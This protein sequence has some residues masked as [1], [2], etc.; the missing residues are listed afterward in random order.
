MDTKAGAAPKSKAEDANLPEQ[1]GCGPIQFMAGD[2]LYQRHLHFD[3]VADEDSIGPRE[4]FEAAAHSVR[5]ILAQRWVLTEKTYEQKN[6]KRV[7]YLSMEFLAEKTKNNI[8]NLFAGSDRHM[9]AKKN[10]VDLRFR[11]WIKRMMQASVTG[12][13]AAWRPVF[14]TPWPLCSFRLWATG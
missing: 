4:H 3:N 7:Y 13:L 12:D 1:Y 8:T 6:A 11:F 10:N 5:D 2:G 9:A 14:L